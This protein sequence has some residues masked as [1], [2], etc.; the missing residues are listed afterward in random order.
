HEPHLRAEVVRRR[1]GFEND[2]VGFNVL[3]QESEEEER[4][5]LLQAR[6]LLP[7]VELP[8]RML[9]LI[10]RICSDLEVDGLRADIVM[11][12]TAL[13]HA[14]YQGRES[15]TPEDV[16][17]AAMLALTHRRRRQP[18]DDASSDPGELDRRVQA[19]VSKVE[20]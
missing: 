6:D 11:Y 8:D 17:V 1:A 5:R 20:A 16:R 18:F 19:Q 9:D 13:T 10:T 15:V 3:W 2:P 14:A 7:D 4:Q 12:K